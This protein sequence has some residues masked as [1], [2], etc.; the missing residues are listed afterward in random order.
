MPL[1]VNDPHIFGTE[2]PFP[3]A[4]AQELLERLE[5]IEAPMFRVPKMIAMDGTMFGIHAG[6]TFQGTRVN[7]WSTGT[8]EWSSLVQFFEATVSSFE[9]LLPRSTLREA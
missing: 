3:S 8:D 9:S 6:N 4:Q 2:S 1:N 7:W 5:T